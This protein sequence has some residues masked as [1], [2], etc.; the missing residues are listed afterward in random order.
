MEKDLFVQ[1]WSFFKKKNIAKF[2]LRCKL[3]NPWP[4]KEREKGKSGFDKLN[5]RVVQWF[6]HWVE[7]RWLVLFTLDIPSVRKSVGTQVVS[8]RGRISCMIQTFHII[9][10]NC[11]KCDWL[12]IYAIAHSV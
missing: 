4:T 5:W 3:R 11:M 10:H 12:F 8:M 7:C 9:S 2:V 1:N 6:S